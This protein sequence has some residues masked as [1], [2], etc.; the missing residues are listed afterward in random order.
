[1]LRCRSQM[2][3]GSGVAGLWNQAAPIALIQPLALELPF[4]AGV[5]MKKKKKRKNVEKEKEWKSTFQKKNPG[6]TTSAS[7][8]RLIS[9]VISHIENIYLWYDVVRMALYL[10][11]LL[12]GTHNPYLSMGKMLWELRSWKKVQTS[13]HK[14]TT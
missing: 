8:S 1:M 4:A 6:K 9:S 3:L 11:C 5:A 12:P 13:P 14:Q 2:W 7:W 10:C